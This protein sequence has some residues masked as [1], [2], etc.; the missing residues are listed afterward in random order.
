MVYKTKKFNKIL[1]LLLVLSFSAEAKLS[2]TE[3]FYRCYG[4]ITGEYAGGNQSY[5]DKLKSGRDPIDLCSE[6]IRN[7]SFTKNNGGEVT[8]KSNGL[9]LAVMKTMHNLHY[10]W[11]SQKGMTDVQDQFVRNALNVFGSTSPAV[12]MTKALFDP[13][14]LYKNIVKGSDTYVALRT[15]YSQKSLSPSLRNGISAHYSKN[16]WSVKGINFAMV[17]DIIGAKKMV[18]NHEL[19]V[20]GKKYKYNKH[21]G[22]GI[23]GSTPYLLANVQP[24][25]FWVFPNGGLYTYRK[26]SRSVY[27][28]ILCRSL[29]IVRESDAKQFARPSSVLPFRQSKSC[30]KCHMSMDPMAGLIRNFDLDGAG[31]ATQDLGHIAITRSESGGQV[32]DKKKINDYF[33]D[34]N[35]GDY[36]KLFAGGSLYYRTHDGEFVQEPDI[37]SLDDLGTI[38][39]SKDDMYAC[40]AKRYFKYFTGIE[41]QIGDINDPD[42]RVLNAKEIKYRNIVI[43]LGKELKGHQDPKK[44]IYKILQLPEY[45]SKDFGI[46][47]SNE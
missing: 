2:N 19:T 27:K 23:I 29:P 33:P 22:G 8:N 18:R 37:K 41:T 46:R 13:N 42:H 24:T 38:F 34:R 43:G 3:L 4:Q 15:N 35:M 26:W 40:L 36:H 6:I 32:Y 47:G 21:W 14:F 39:S 9:S 12:H 11:F 44:T 28:D 17:G 1:W 10:S 20:A 5:I 45:K 31:S 25:S 7:V 16:E 30:T